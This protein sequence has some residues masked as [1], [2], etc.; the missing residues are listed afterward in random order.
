MSFSCEIMRKFM[1]FRCIFYGNSF[2]LPQQCSVFIAAGVCRIED[3][4]ITNQSG[5]G[6]CNAISDLFIYLFMYLFIISL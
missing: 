3:C 6:S 1:V 4:Q 2:R 5:G